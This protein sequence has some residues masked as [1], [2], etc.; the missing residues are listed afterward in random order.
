[1]VATV[2]GPVAPPTGTTAVILESETT[3]NAAFTPPNFTAVAPVKPT[4][5]IVT[6]VPGRPAMS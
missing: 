2:S 4:P 3:V 1:V 5:L 6:F